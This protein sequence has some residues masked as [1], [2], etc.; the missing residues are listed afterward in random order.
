M[1][2]R[3]HARADRKEE[4]LIKKRKL[5]MVSTPVGTELQSDAQEVLNQLNLKT[6]VDFD[7]AFLDAQIA[8]H[9]RV[10]GLIDNTLLPEASSGDVKTLIRDLRPAVQ[11]HLDE[12]R[13]LQ[14][15]IKE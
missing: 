1:I 4:D 14:M 15:K 13:S 3:Q 8:G 10:L 12:A 6:G 9:R 2:L 11:G 5:D 7:R